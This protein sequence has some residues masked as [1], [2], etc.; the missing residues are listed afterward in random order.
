MAMQ[1]TA[2]AQVVGNAFVEQYYQIQ[3]RSPDEVYRF[4]QN[5]S[6][7]SRPDSNGVMSSVTT[8]DVSISSIGLFTFMIC[9]V[10]ERCCARENIN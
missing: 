9:N 4:Y 10:L 8:M 2:S 5:S 1:T 3:H 6:V 7:L